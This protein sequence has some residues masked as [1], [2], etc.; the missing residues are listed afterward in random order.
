MK[1]FLI[2]LLSFVLF[3]F[4]E[5][6]ILVSIYP[7]YDV[8]KDIS[9]KYYRVESLVPPKA[10][11]HVYEL[12]PRELIKLYRAKV[13][14]VSGVP[15]GEWEEKVEKIAKGKVYSL[16]KGIELIT[17]G[18]E[19]LGKDPHFWV[20]P[21]RMLKVA[22]NVEEALTETFKKNF[23]ENYKNVEQEL[24]KLDEAYTK[25]LSKC[26]YKKFGAVHGAFGYLAKDYGLEQVLLREEHGHG[27]I[28]PSE[29]KKL[30][31][32]IKK[33]EIKVVLIPKGVHSKFA[34]ILK[35]TYNIT[36]YEVN[37]KIIPEEE[38]D[39]YYKIMERNLKVLKE[40][41]KCG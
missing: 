35:E 22:K 8:V 31:K 26:E 10:D 19:E 2:I 4:P 15:L 38:G 16:S 36:V 9:G 25:T 34:E 39:N 23:S 17:Y 29:L 14:F 20:S 33:K 12:T 24:K 37:V 11:Y 32:L 30:V 21:K 13:V 6:L 1:K 41:L 18:H 28:S 7:F 40:A 5:D 3:V 27:D